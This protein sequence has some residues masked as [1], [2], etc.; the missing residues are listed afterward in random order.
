MTNTSCHPYLQGH[1][2]HL[3]NERGQ[4]LFGRGRTHA[5]AVRGQIERGRLQH[6][7]QNVLD[8][9]GEREE[10]SPGHGNRIDGSGHFWK[11]AQVGY[12]AGIHECI[13]LKDI[14]RCLILLMFNT[15][16]LIRNQ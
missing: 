13:Q 15:Q 4:I 2:L 10:R 9:L 12:F 8:G 7:L 3:I 16:L 5:A 11:L 14:V 1:P 6:V